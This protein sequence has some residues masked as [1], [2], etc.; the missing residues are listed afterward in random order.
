MTI[1]YKG[2]GHSGASQV[3][4]PTS[5]APT[6]ENVKNTSLGILAVSEVRVL[7][8]SY[9]KRRRRHLQEYPLSLGLTSAII[10]NKHACLV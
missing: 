5:D 7:R 1:L 9:A 6:I 10:N 4:I 2:Q 3:G 8:I